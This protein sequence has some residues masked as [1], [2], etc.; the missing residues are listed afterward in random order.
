[1]QRRRRRT[2]RWRAAESRRVFRICSS[3][4]FQ[5]PRSKIIRLLPVTRIGHAPHAEVTHAN[6]FAPRVCIG[7]VESCSAI[8]RY[9]LQL[10]TAYVCSLS[11]LTRHNAHYLIPAFVCLHRRATS[12]AD[13]CTADDAPNKR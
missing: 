1:M 8:P 13:V 6:P 9:I 3:P 2:R 10:R 4:S 11:P 12:A 7:R 5:R